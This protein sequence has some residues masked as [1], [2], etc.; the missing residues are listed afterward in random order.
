MNLYLLTQ[1][2]N[3]NY[4]TF[5]SAVVAAETEEKAR[6]IHPRGDREYSSLVH[7]WYREGTGGVRYYDGKHSAW[8]PE[9]APIDKV[10]VTHL[11]TAKPGTKK[12]VI[13]ASFNAG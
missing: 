2:V 5:D 6:L 3:N 10:E 7:D 13:C 4:D 8:A 9:W 12:G 1:T 11:G